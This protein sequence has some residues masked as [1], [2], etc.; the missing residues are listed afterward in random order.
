MGLNN[1]LIITKS[2]IKEF[3]WILLFLVQIKPGYIN[4][5]PMVNEIYNY[6]RYASF[7]Y[8][9]FLWL[10]RATK[11]KLDVAA[12]PVIL[13]QIYIFLATVVNRQDVKQS[14]LLLF[15]VISI[16][17]LFD[18]LFKKN[19]LVAVN[20]ILTSYEIYV[21][22]NLASIILFPEGL[23]SQ[24][25][26]RVATF[27]G[28]ANTSIY[29]ILPMLVFG[30]LFNHMSKK[31]HN[32]RMMLD[33]CVSI[34][35]IGILRSATSTVE[36]MLFAIIILLCHKEK[37]RKHITVLNSFIISSILSLCV[38]ILRIQ[39][40]FAAVINF[41]FQRSSDLTGRTMLWDYALL[42]IT[43]NP[44]I[45]HGIRD[46]HHLRFGVG[47][48]N[49][50]LEILYEGGIIALALFIVIAVMV[51]K[52]MNRLQ[53]S[54]KFAVPIIAAISVQFFGGITESNITSTYYYIPIILALLLYDGRQAL[55]NMSDRWK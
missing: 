54:G 41:L 52:K 40:K 44:I 14:A 13:F 6:G 12:W 55:S 36:I 20:S 2:N 33:I 7:I 39:E 30:Y 47:T 50:L 17:L 23:Y 26:E 24:V 37:M 4:L 45:G 9:L 28:H 49:M 35:T 51:N 25:S 18:Y 34:I 22:I 32:F 21:Y 31:K 38:T 16:A 5:L 10:Y 29:F 15:S 46:V 19:P 48:H 3:F 53:Y 27:L 43:A 42:D 11:G 8:I 1:R